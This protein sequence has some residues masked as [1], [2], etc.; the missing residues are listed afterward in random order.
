MFQ[1]KKTEIK[2]DRNGEY[3]NECKTFIIYRLVDCN[4]YEILFWFVFF[5]FWFFYFQYILL[6]FRIPN[7][8]LFF[9]PMISIICHSFSP[10]SVNLVSIKFAM[11][12][13]TIVLPTIW[14]HR[15]CNIILYRFVLEKNFKLYNL[16]Y[17]VIFW[18]GI[19]LDFKI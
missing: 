11:I 12:T 3:W 7:S 6:W 2:T 16:F 4:S 13:V 5:H 14:P 8:H 19:V 15:N 9:I 17:L 18:F 10:I 1:R